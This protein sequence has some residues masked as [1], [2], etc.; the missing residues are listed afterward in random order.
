MSQA[1]CLFRGRVCFIEPFFLLF[2]YSFQLALRLLNP[3]WDEVIDN[4][5]LTLPFL[6]KTFFLL[7]FNVSLSTVWGC[8]GMNEMFTADY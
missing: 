1:T 7:T 5:I 2:N 6:K 8:L 3:I 4:E